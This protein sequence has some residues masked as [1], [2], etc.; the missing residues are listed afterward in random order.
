MT[1]KNTKPKD[2]DD[3]VL[4]GAEAIGKEINREPR[5]TYYL[6]EKGFVPGTKVGGV[7]T[8]T[9]R[10]LRKHFAGEEA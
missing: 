3:E 6:L 2:L 8:S 5:P 4:W 7:W 1:T 10:R 9:R